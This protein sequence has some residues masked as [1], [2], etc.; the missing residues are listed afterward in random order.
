LNPE[1]RQ[2]LLLTCE[3][4][5]NAVPARWAHLFD[6]P[7][8]RDALASHRGWDPGAATLAQ[9][10]SSPTSLSSEALAKE[11]DLGHLSPV[12]RPLSPLPGLLGTAT[13]LLV[14]LNRS[15]GHPQFWSE[16]S[17]GLPSAEKE[18]IVREVYDPFRRA[19]RAEIERRSGPHHAPVFHLSV[20]T[21]TPHL[22]GDVRTAEIGLLYDPERPLEVGWVQAWEQAL[23]T[24]APGWRIR[25]NYPYLGTDDGHVTHLRTRYPPGAYAGIELEVNQTLVSDSENRPAAREILR[26]ALHDSLR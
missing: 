18:H 8:A 23:R 4:A 21:F 7:A 15:P 24:L 22:D 1:P 5:T 9:C 26:R 19:A 12:P 16:F 10:L 14:D 20:H 3:H 17:R 25:R 6:S 2:R 11:D 13:R